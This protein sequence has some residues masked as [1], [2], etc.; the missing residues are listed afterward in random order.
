M[1]VK[2]VDERKQKILRAII[3]E[4]IFRAEPIGSRTL[5]K[6][7]DLGVSSATIRNEMSDLEELGYLEQPHTSAGRIPS[8]KG[9]RYYVDVL[10]E[11]HND[12]PP[13]LERAL[14][15]FYKERQGV[16]EIMSGMVKMLSRM[17]RYAV[18]ISEP[19]LQK[20]KIKKVEL[21]NLARHSLLIVLITDTGIVNN[22][23]IKLNKELTPRE[24]RYINRFLVSKLRDK[25]LAV[26]NADYLKSVEKELVKKINLSQELFNLINDELEHIID[27]GDIEIYLGGTSYILEQPEFTDLATL[28]KVLNILDQK[29]ILRKLIATSSKEG[30]E[31]KI[32]QE[33]KLAEMENCSVVFSTYSLKGSASGKI[34]VIGPTRMEYTRVITTVDFV[35]QVLGKIISEV[36]G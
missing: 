2:E 21:V 36:S 3:Q 9:Y 14:E 22:K 23:V 8:D 10:M 26:L 19:R 17:T 20:S 5:S 11:Q 1:M 28:K 25:E 34:G 15:S 33:N 12:V 30:L 32:G 18:L 4:H 24:L 27:P 16:Q 31:V 6:N 35:S 7:Y 13:E 29:E